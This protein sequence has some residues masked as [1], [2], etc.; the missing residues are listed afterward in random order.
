MMKKRR[1]L[2]HVIPACFWRESSGV[3]FNYEQKTFTTEAQRHRGAQRKPL[4]RF[5]PC[6]C[7]SVVNAFKIL[8]SMERK[9]L[10]SRQ[11][12]AGMTT[13]GCNGMAKQTQGGY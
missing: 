1:P 5:S 11:K 13:A 10:D 12:H 2:S 3:D 6:L 7:A 4:V 9:T 8:V